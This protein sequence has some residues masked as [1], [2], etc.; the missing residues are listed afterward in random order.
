MAGWQGFPSLHYLLEFLVWLRWLDDFHQ[1]E[2]LFGKEW[3]TVSKQ[4]LARMVMSTAL[5]V[6]ACYYEAKSP[7]PPN[8]CLKNL[9]DE[10]R[11]DLMYDLEI[12]WR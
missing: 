7:F 10:Q 4:S 8:S 1:Y 9:R 2:H 11:I 5:I 12:A 6:E 3:P